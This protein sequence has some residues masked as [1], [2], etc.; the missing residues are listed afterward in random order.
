MIITIVT[1]ENRVESYDSILSHYYDPETNSIDIDTG[2]TIIRVDDV[3]HFTL[4]SNTGTE[5]L[6]A[7]NLDKGLMRWH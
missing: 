6:N 2:I 5:I 7:Q 1:T 3:K 4:F